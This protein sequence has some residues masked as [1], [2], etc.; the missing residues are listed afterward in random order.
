[1]RKQVD[2]ILRVV[3]DTNIRIRILLRGK[4]TL[5]VL[6]AFNENKFQL[7]MSQFN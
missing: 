5:P 2:I 1:V 4:V 6:E 7:I 3:I